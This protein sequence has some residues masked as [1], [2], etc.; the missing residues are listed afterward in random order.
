MDAH[1]NALAKGGLLYDVRG[2]KSTTCD[3]LLVDQASDFTRE[4]KDTFS[5]PRIKALKVSYCILL[6][7]PFVEALADFEGDPLSDEA[8]EWRKQF[9]VCVP[10]VD[11]RTGRAS[12]PGAF[13]VH[14]DLVASSARK[15]A[16]LRAAARGTPLPPAGE[17]GF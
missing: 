9:T 1:L 14:P 5:K 2:T 6:L 3:I 16:E 8:L 15:I 4:F 17:D 13:M 11:E 10:Y 12:R 7:Q